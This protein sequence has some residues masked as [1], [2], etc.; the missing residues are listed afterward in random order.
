MRLG[1]VL[2]GYRFN[3]GIGVRKLAA[4]I[5]ISAATYSRVERGYPMD[6]TT[7]LAIWRWLTTARASPM[8]NCDA[9]H[10]LWTLSGDSE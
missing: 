7:L 9:P 2:A 4:E 6:A 10:V 1:E 5:G 3:R 8:T